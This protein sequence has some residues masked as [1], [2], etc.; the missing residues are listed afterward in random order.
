M[1]KRRLVLPA[2]AVCLLVTSALRL[3]TFFV[4]IKPAVTAENFQRLHEGMTEEEVEAILGENP[5]L[6]APAVKV[7]KGAEG[8]SEISFYPSGSGDSLA[9]RGLFCGDDG[10]R[11]ELRPKPESWKEKLSR[12]GFLP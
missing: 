10:L 3:W 11:L 1:T 5:A 8:C 9:R 2:I 7:W 12:W 6:S 4:L